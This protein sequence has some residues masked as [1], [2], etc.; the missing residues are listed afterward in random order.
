MPELENITVKVTGKDELSASLTGA[1]VA[2]VGL[3]QALQLV[4]QISKG[5][6][7][8]INGTV[9]E[10]LTYADTVRHV[11]QI[12]GEGT[13]QASRLVQVMKDMGISS[14][15]MTTMMSTA[16]K[17]GFTPTIE[18]IEKAADKYNSLNTVTDRNNFLIQTFGKNGLQWAQILG[19]GSQK[20]GELNNGVN[21]NLVLNTN[22]VNA[23]RALELQQAKLN[24]SWEAVKISL[25]EILIPALTKLVDWINNSINGWMQLIYCLKGMAAPALAA[26]AS[27]IDDTSTSMLD[28]GDSTV[29]T[30]QKLRDYSSQ[31]SDILTLQDQLDSYNKSM[32]GAEK[33]LADARA[34]GVAEDSDEMIALKQKVQD[35]QDAEDT[36]TKKFLL[37]M[38]QQSLAADGVFSADDM[39]KVINMGESMGVLSQNTVDLYNQYMQLTGAEANY[40]A[41]FGG[42]GTSVKTSTPTVTYADLAAYQAAHGVTAVNVASVLAGQQI[43]SGVPTDKP[44]NYEPAIAAAISYAPATPSNLPTNNGNAGDIGN[45]VVNWVVNSALPW[46]KGLGNSNPTPTNGLFQAEGGDYMVSKPTLFMAGEAGAERATFTP[47]NKTG[48]DN[49]VVNAINQLGSRIDASKLDENK[50]SRLIRDAVLVI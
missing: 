42:G 24:Q 50:L 25:G 6:E 28:L 31:M 36:W 5:V 22:D 23:G 35:V 9:G 21:Q 11:A 37:N 48:G 49:D 4:Q 12:T 1:A 33:D 13:E 34:A 41:A 45:A 10:F 15:T 3:N 16:I 18:N 39:Q 30:T 27:S 38:Y 44:A 40:E 43:A 47:L 26:V 8:V 46:L 32:A 29:G 19:L 7:D 17:K 14:D 2:A 20:I